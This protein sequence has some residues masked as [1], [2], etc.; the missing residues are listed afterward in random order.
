MTNPRYM[1]NGTDFAIGKLIEELGELQ[2]ALGKMLRWGPD[3]VNPELPKHL[4]ESNRDW[5][6]REI[7]DVIEAIANY[8]RFK[9]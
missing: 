8:Q 9:P 5:V 3:S 1:R 2:T 4:Q 6:D 7:S